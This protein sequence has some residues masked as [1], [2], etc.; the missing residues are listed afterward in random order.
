VAASVPLLGLLWHI[1]FLVV[2]RLV[3]PR[4]SFPTDMAAQFADTLAVTFVPTVLMGMVFPLAIQICAPAWQTV[5]QHVGRVY[6]CN[7]IGC[8]LGSFLAGFVLMPQLGL[9]DS[10]L[11]ILALLFLLALFLI[12]LSGRRR[13]LWAVP[14]SIISLSLLVVGA[15]VV[16]RDVFLRTMNTYHYPSKIV[17]LDDGVTGTVTVHDLPDGDRLIAIDGIDVAGVDLML[18]TTQKLQAY[19]RCWSGT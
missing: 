11:V 6:A 13:A 18:R 14:V 9:R 7:T 4:V 8:V 16:P 19:A 1:D 3:G 5:G 10:F 17:Y 15:A 2:E 12:L